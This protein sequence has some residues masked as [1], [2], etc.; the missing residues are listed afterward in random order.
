MYDRKFFD[1][2]LGQAAVASV[3]AML[4]LIAVSSQLNATHNPASP[5]AFDHVAVEIA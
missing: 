5:L 3:G 2:K 1:S 4:V